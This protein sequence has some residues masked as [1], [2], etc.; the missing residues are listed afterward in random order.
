MGGADADQDG[1]DGEQ[2]ADSEECESEHVWGRWK[3]C[4]NTRRRPW[5]PSE[6]DEFSEIS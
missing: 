6:S 4:S 2:H 5:G 3:V 1:G